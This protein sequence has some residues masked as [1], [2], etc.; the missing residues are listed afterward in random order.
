MNEGKLPDQQ[1]EGPF[2]FEDLPEGDGVLILSAQ[3]RILS[4]SLQAERLLHRELRRGQILSLDQL[5]G[6]TCLPRPRRPWMKPW[7]GLPEP[8][9]WPRSGCR[10]PPVFT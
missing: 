2:D 8:T 5:F 4:A 7:R 3:R 1:P 10:G 6:A 9:C